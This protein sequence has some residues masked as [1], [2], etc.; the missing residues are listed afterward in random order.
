MNFKQ[1]N[2]DSLKEALKITKAN[3]RSS[4]EIKKINAYKHNCNGS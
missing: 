1:N 3:S 4:H 2:K